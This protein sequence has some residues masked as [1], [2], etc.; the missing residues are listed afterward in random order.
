MENQKNSQISPLLL[1]IPLIIAATGMILII[2]TLTMKPASTGKINI[3]L[4]GN[5]YIIKSDNGGDIIQ[6]VNKDGEKEKFEFS[7]S[8]K[9]HIWDNRFST[10]RA[11]GYPFSDTDRIIDISFDISGSVKVENRR[12][13]KYCKD[14]FAKLYRYLKDLG[15]KPG[16]RIRARLFGENKV[17]AY[18]TL[19]KLLEIEYLGPKFDYEL[20]YSTGRQKARV[21]LYGHQF[22]DTTVSDRGIVEVSSFKD[23][24][25][26]L[27]NYYFTAANTPGTE[28]NNTYLINNLITTFTENKNVSYNSII[29]VLLTDGAFSIESGLT[30]ELG[31]SYFSESDYRDHNKISAFFD[32]YGLVING[33]KIDLK[34]DKDGKMVL[35]GFSND[36]HDYSFE[37]AAY[38][39]FGS[40][41]NGC[42]VEFLP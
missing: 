29:Y 18:K 10:G 21:T 6:Y 12:T 33:D 38:Q 9:K 20:Q 27:S 7:D 42:K 34:D 28:D 13:G 5:Q 1:I 15:L 4:I 30:K 14:Q 39:V 16:D 2:Y 36:M 32:H 8:M 3:Q 40:M 24:I 31:T 26:S 17:I 25:S 11:W 19:P 41:Y 35:I 23:A 37:N 22:T